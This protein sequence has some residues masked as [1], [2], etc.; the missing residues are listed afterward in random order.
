VSKLCEGPE[1]VR[2]VSSRGLCSAHAKQRGRGIP[3]RVIASRGVI[4]YGPDEVCFG[5]ECDKPPDGRGMCSAH[6]HQW[7]KGR[8]LTAVKR[9]TAPPPARSEG[10]KVC[11]FEGCDQSRWRQG[12]CRPHR[13]SLPRN[14]GCQTCED[15]SWLWAAGESPEH[16]AARVGLSWVSL[17][18]HLERHDV[19]LRERM[20]R[21]R[22]V[23]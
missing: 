7:K 4:R 22:W 12:L 1:C 11:V 17:E 3:L 19:E 16:V 23:A 21:S 9:K 14:F 18:R 20:A 8:P 10:A 5:P 15:V 2:A 6:W 13:E